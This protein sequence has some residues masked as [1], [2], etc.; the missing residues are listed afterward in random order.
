M[1]KT[2]LNRIKAFGMTNQMVIEDLTRVAERYS[3][4]LKHLP[5]TK[6]EVDETYFPQFDLQ[7]R[8]DASAMSK[9]YEAIYCL[10]NSIR[11]L[12]SSTLSTTDDT[13]TWWT[14]NTIPEHIINEVKLRISKELD[15]GI[16]RRSADPL[17]YTT[18][19]I[20]TDN[21]IKLG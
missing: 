8:S 7:I 1:N 5:T 18:W 12:V 21:A 10:E 14:K 2:V 3:I 20:I 13:S 4:D 17:A 9:H 6:T 19:G 15:E 16:S 11:S